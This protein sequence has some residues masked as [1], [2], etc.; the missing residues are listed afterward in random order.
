MFRIPKK[1]ILI[2][3]LLVAGYFP[4]SAQ[5]QG[6]NRWSLQ[7]AVD[8]ALAHNL[9]VKLSSLNTEVSKINLRESRAAQLPGLTGNVNENYNTGR[10]IDPFTNNFVNQKIWSTGLSLNANV[11][12]FSGMQLKNS[13]QQSRIDLQASEADLAKAK[14]DMILNIVT[15]YMQVLFN[16]ELLTTAKLNLSTSESQA[17]RVEKLYK[18]GS[19]AET[20]LLEINAQVASDEL[21]VINAQNNKDIAELN[22][23][24]LLDLQDKTNF[25]VEKPAI[26]EP[27]QSVIGFNAEQV[28]ESAQQTQPEITAA[29]LRVRSAV[30]GVDVSR[31]NYYPR[32]TLSGSVSTGY[33][34]ARQATSVD[35]VIFTPSTFYLDPNGGSPTTIYTPAPN[36]VVT[37]YPFGKQFNDNVSNA[38][39]LNLSIPIFN[40]FQARYGVQRSMVNVRNAE[41]N[42]QLEKNTLRQKVEQ[43]YA[44]AT[45]AQKKY[46]AAK[47]QLASFEKAYK[48]SEIRFNNGILNS[49]DFNV[50]KN[51]FIKAQSDIIQAKYDYTFKLKILDFYQGKPITF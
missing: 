3:A 27:D 51:N 14:N 30:K 29:N 21:N 26:P 35:G 25:E 28:F 49:T 41:L 45:A 11:T 12:L 17:S 15:A 24:Q 38:I 7:R 18:A 22:L 5:S 13:V 37:D 31:G 6:G 19:V 46:V 39:S 47:K 48:N 1:S 10:S 20:N 9:Q 44:D 42:L 33:S 23:M 4:A 8:H 50:S 43:A 2:A 34:S 16:D 36:F 32:L 40:R